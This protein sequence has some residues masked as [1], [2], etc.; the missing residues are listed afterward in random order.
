MS[1][2]I[3]LFLILIVLKS[4]NCI[5]ET[6]LLTIIQ[7]NFVKGLLVIFNPEPAN[8]KSCVFGVISLTDRG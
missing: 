2:T 8:G 5:D 7:T 4:I 3:K 1:Q 6:K